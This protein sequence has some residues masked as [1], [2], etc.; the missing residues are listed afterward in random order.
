M[1]VVGD[2]GVTRCLNKGQGLT[3][4]ALEI[5]PVIK[6]VV[7]GIGD[8]AVQYKIAGGSPYRFCPAL[9]NDSVPFG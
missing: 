7:T 3:N 2:S 4:S 1:V 9:R 5:H 8:N 6:I